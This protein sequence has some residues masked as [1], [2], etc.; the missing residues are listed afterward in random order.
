M[1]KFKSN[2]NHLRQSYYVEGEPLGII[3][4]QGALPHLIVGKRVNLP[5]YIVAIK[6][7]TPQNVAEVAPH[8]WFGFGEIGKMLSYLQ[9]NNITQITMAGRLTR[10]ALSAIK[11]DEKGVELLKTLGGSLLRGDNSLLSGII[12]FLEKHNVR[13]VGAH[14]ICRDLLA[15]I[16]C[17]TQTQPLED[18]ERDFLLAK[19]LLQAISPFDIGQAVVMQAGVVLGIEGLEGTATLI[20]RTATLRHESPTKPILVKLPKTAQEL[21]ADMPAIG[22]DTVKAM[23]EAAFAGAYL[24]ANKTLMLDKLQIIAQANQDGLFI[25]GVKI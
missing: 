9:K 12:G 24:A 19:D 3:A 16:G 4:G 10:P 22:V 5:N 23:R 21:R 14:E 13:V 18:N 8:E 15:D 11:P 2:N 7:Q 25:S 17:M 1:F 6:E 20:E